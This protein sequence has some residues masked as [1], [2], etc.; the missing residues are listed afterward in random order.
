MFPSHFPFRSNGLTSLRLKNFWLGLSGS[1]SLSSSEDSFYSMS[2]YSSF[3]VGV[4]FFSSS[5][6]LTY[7]DLIRNQDLYNHFH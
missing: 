7:I 4:L 1:K 6:M 5:V 2:S 3:L